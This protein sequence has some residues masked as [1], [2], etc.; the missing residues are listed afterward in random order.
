MEVLVRPVPK[1]QRSVYLGGPIDYVRADDE[2]HQRREWIQ[3]G[4]HPYCPRCEC[5]GLSDE[6]AMTQNM[7]AVKESW[8]CV[9][10]L[11]ART[12]GTPIEMFLRCWVH[13][14][15]AIIIGGRESLFVRQTMDRFNVPVVRNHEDTL[16]QIQEML[17]NG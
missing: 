9:F 12:I 1:T 7:F 5:Q 15:P 10:D 8:L 17:S 11:R 4:L 6:E 3:W 2:W 13:E 16:R 14:R